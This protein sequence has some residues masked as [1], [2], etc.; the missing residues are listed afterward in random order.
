MYLDGFLRVFGLELS[1]GPLVNAN[2]GAWML[3]RSAITITMLKIFAISFL[4]ILVF[5]NMPSFP[6]VGQNSSVFGF[7]LFWLHS[8]HGSM[9]LGFLT[10]FSVVANSINVPTNISTLHL[11]H[12]K[13]AVQLVAKAISDSKYRGYANYV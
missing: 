6:H 7:G 1:A 9:G 2:T 4:F 12:G 5:G 3:R 11:P 13:F 8:G 10:N